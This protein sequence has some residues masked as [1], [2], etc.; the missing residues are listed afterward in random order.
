MRK[1]P[2]MLGRSWGLCAVLW[3][4]GA[5]STPAAC[6]AAG[7]ADVSTLCEDWVVPLDLVFVVSA[8]A[9]HA[10]SALFLHEKTNATALGGL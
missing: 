9:A 1:W 7:G 10:A 5:H 8:R 4:M 2:R 3:R 6:A